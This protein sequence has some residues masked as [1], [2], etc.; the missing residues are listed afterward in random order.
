MPLSA[1]YNLEKS[2]LAVWYISETPEYL[3]QK[4]IIDD[5]IPF[6]NERRNTHW[7]AARLALQEV[8]PFVDFKI[9]KN[10]H[11]KPYLEN[12]DAH[13]SISHSGNLAAAIYNSQNLCGIDL[14]KFDIRINKI[15][16]KFTSENETNLLIPEFY[17]S[18]CCLIW[19]AK[20]T[21]FKYSPLPEI[22]FKN[23]IELTKIDAQKQFMSFCFKKNN[24]IC[25]EVNYKI[26]EVENFIIKETELLTD[27]LMSEKEHYILTWI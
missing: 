1:K 3:L 10:L 25:L 26:F 12:S 23:H 19:S 11:G 2:S 18:F 16:Y 21:I 20:E 27:K 13:I 17:N 15:A 5:Y 4:L 9:I 7:L 22:D 6:K 24:N 8:L 14:E